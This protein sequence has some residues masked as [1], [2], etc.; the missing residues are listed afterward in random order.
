MD[1]RT[2]KYVVEII[3]LLHKK[4]TYR[5]SR[6]IDSDF[7]LANCVKIVK[8]TYA[9]IDLFISF[10]SHRTEIHQQHFLSKPPNIMFANIS[11]CTVYRVGEWK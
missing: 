11:T 10:S 7:N 3:I 8:L 4:T 9:I 1:T 2:Y 5:I 6:N